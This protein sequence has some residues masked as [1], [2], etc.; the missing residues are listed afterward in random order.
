[1]NSS[2]ASVA[3][4][5]FAYAG[6]AALALAM[7]RHYADAFGRGESPSPSLRR[8][9]QMVGSL[10]LVL[11]LAMN[12]AGAGWAFGSLYWLGGLTLAALTLAL[13]LAYVP[14]LGLRAAVPSVGLALMTTALS[15]TLR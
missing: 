9:M 13:L 15:L 4:I 3:G 11:S 7:D 6:F 12:V 1:M 5:F 14:R 10:A 2:C 8:T